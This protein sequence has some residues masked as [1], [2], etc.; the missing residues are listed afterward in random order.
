MHEN[1]EISSH[2]FES[3]RRPVREGHKPN[4]GHARAGEVG[5]RRTTCEPTEQGKATPAEAGEG[6]AQLEENIVQPRMLLTL[7]RK[8]ACPC[9]WTVRVTQASCTGS[10]SRHSSF[11]RAVCVDAHVRICAGCALKAHEVQS[12]EMGTA[13]KPSSQPRTKSC[14][15]SGDGHCEA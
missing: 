8:S 13:V 1:R 4:G 15:M 14:V 12:P 3:M 9:V 6:R 2:A 11:R 7:S 5:L 10:L